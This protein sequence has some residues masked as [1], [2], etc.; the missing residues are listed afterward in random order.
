[1]CSPS[2]PAREGEG[3]VSRHETLSAVRLFCGLEL[4]GM[5]TYNALPLIL[6][7]LRIGDYQLDLFDRNPA[8]SPVLVAMY[9]LANSQG[10]P[11]IGLLA[12]NLERIL[13]AF[14]MG[15]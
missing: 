11:L 3:R 4:M 5:L 9:N 12:G 14:G 10:I 8:Q 1:V 6:L 2:V 15:R 7:Y 13:Q